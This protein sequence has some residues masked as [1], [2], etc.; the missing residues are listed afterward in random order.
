MDANLL[1]L[2]E[3]SMATPFIVLVGGGVLVG[4]Q[5]TPA[6]EATLSGLPQVLGRVE[7]TAR[8]RY[9]TDAEVDQLLTEDN[10][11]YRELVETSGPLAV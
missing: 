1:S 2:A 5:I 8:L 6:A 3:P 11:R 9:L 7:E 10:Y 4:E